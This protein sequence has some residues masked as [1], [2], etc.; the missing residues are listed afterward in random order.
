MAV[1]FKHLVPVPVPVKI[2]IMVPV[3][4]L[5]VGNRR[6]VPVPVTET[7]GVGGVAGASFRVPVPV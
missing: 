4:A 2:P 1:I 3:P 5:V 7:F 6:L